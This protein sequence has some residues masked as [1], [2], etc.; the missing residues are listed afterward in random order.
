METN[1][2]F[3]ILRNCLNGIRQVMCNNEEENYYIIP[4]AKK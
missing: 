3:P 2:N 1:D 4:G